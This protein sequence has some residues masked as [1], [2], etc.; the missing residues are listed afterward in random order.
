MSLLASIPR[1]IKTRLKAGLSA[2][3]KIWVRAFRSYGPAQ[4]RESLTRLGLAPGDTVI[5]HGAFGHHHGFRGS[6]EDLTN[7]FVDLLGPQGTLAMVSLP[8]RSSSLQYLQTMKRFDVRRTP[9]MMGL[10][11]E[12]FRHRPGVLR[13][14]H[15]THPVLALGARA[16]W[17]VESHE[18]SLYP[19]G[20]GTPFEKMLLADGKV[21][22]FNVPFATFT[23]FHYLE[24]HVSSRVP[25]KLYTDE[26]FAVP[27]VDHA[28]QSRT[29]NTFVFSSD[30]IRRRRFP[31][32]ED[33]LRQRGLI[34]QVRVGATRLEAIRLRDALECV[35]EMWRNQRYF[36]DMAGPDQ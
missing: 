7:V 6:I 23:F 11:S 34:M 4:L 12:Y 28:G 13:S 29:V 31:V 18:N 32:L 20:P 10:I 33:E 35:E 9:S 25:F 8:Y 2:G 19:C 15:P 26:P 27:V 1:P 21:V 36:Y 16:K 30:A 14:L 17:L 5:L 24:H 3:R 22:F